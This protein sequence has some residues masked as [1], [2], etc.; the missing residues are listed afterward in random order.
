MLEL[1]LELEL[2]L[3]SGQGQGQGRE[4]GARMMSGIS[5][6]FYHLWLLSIPTFTSLCYD[7]T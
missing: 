5:G 1:V 7:L 6:N 4:Q 3:V 2:E